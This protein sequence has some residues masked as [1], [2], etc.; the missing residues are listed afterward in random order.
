MCTEKDDMVTIVREILHQKL[1]KKHHTKL[2]RNFASINET[3]EHARVGYNYDIPEK[4]AF[5]FDQWKKRRDAQIQK[6]NGIYES[7]WSREGIDLLKGTASFVDPKTVEVDLQDGSGKASFTA[8]HILVATGG[9]PL[10][11]TGVKG[12]EHGITS[13]GF[14]DIEILPKKIAIVGAGYIAVELAGVLNAI[15]VEVHLFISSTTFLRKFDPMVQDTMTKVYEDAGI[16]IHKNFKGFKLVER[17]DT[18]TSSGPSP[19]KVLRLT[20]VEDHT[21]QD[22]NELLW[23]IGRA[24]SIKSLALEKAGVRL[25]K[26]GHIEVDDFQNTNVEGIYALGDVTGKVE[27]TPVA[28][29]A[30]RQLGNRLFGPPHMKSAKLDYNNIPSVVFSHPEVGLHIFGFR[31]L[32]RA[33]F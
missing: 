24:P 8:P 12:A 17:L 19:D 11:P 5:H 21:Y 32:D 22:F 16:I 14:F 4:V 26:S 18:S 3:L 27:L 9:Y 33:C 10:L 31:V 6:L 30:G 13:D 15:G 25:T 1:C 20:D 23:A 28:I 7:N 29:A 2:C